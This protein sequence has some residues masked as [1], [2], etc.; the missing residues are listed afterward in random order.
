MASCVCWRTRVHASLRVDDACALWHVRLPGIDGRALINMLKN[1]VAH[2]FCFGLSNAPRACSS[3]LMRINLLSLCRGEI[4][5]AKVHLLGAPPTSTSQ[6]LKLAPETTDGSSRCFRHPTCHLH[7]IRTARLPVP[8]VTACICSI[9]TYNIICITSKVALIPC[10]Y[11]TQTCTT[12]SGY[13]L[14]TLLTLKPSRMQTWR[15]P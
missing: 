10:C 1:F 13:S 4:T 12:N 15:R 6:V 9:L 5:R 11:N 3:C 2:S 14:Q 7:R 8:V